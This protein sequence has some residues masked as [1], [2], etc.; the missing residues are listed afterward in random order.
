[1]IAY[2]AKRLNATQR[3]YAPTK[4]ELF[5][6]VVFIRHFGYYL[7]HRRFVLRTDHRALLQIKTMDPPMGAIG[8]WLDCISNFD[9]QVVYRKGSQHGNAD[10][11]SR[12]DFIPSEHT[13]EDTG[14]QVSAIH[15]PCSRREQLV[16][17]QLED[18]SLKVVHQWIR[19]NR[20]P[21]KSELSGLPEPLRH[22]ADLRASFSIVDKVLMYQE[23]RSMSLVPVWPE[24]WEKDLIIKAHAHLSHRGP[25]ATAAYL[26]ERVYFP[27]LAQKVSWV[28]SRCSP[29]LV[30]TKPSSR[31]Q[32]RQLHSH[33]SPAPWHTLSID[34]VGPFPPSPQNFRYLLTEKDLFTRWLE[35]F[36]TKDMTTDTVMRILNN[37]LFPRYGYPYRIHADNGTQFASN[38]FHKWC[39]KFGIRITHTPP[40]NPR[41]NPVE[42]AHRDL[43]AALTALCQ[44][45]TSRWVEFLPQ[46]LMAQRVVQCSSTG[47]SPFQLMFGRKPRCEL[48]L[49]FPLPS[50][51][52]VSPQDF[53]ETLFARQQAAFQQA[54][55]VAAQTVER[56]RLQYHGKLPKFHE[57][58]LVWVFIPRP[59]K[60]FVKLAIWWTG[61]WIVVSVLNPLTYAVQFGRTIKPDVK[62]TI[63]AVDRLK[64]YFDDETVPPPVSMDHNPGDPYVETC[65]LPQVAQ[66]EL[67]EHAPEAQLSY[68]YLTEGHQ[69]VVPGPSPS[70]PRHTVPI[71]EPDK[72]VNKQTDPLNDE[73]PSQPDSS[74]DSD[75]EPESDAPVAVSPEAP[76]ATGK[77]SRIRNRLDPLPVIPD[78]PPTERNL[79]YLRR[80]AHKNS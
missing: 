36:P 46:A 69:P 6:A 30:K 33:A 24:C 44:N 78:V 19:Q 21:S 74:S 51:L 42:R 66:D 35:A 77:Y 60:R 18:R 32:H 38:L 1:M 41:S 34:F 3:N 59:P 8:R 56:Q 50:D 20:T 64:P 2:A 48:D 16:K 13:V 61:P 28:I 14:E 67:D 31:G 55:T 68:P 15:L 79:R 63:V 65:N 62:H 54:R 75:S 12:A 37:E 25:E 4:G 73:F 17:Q 5:A 26:Q 45:K 9:F 58:Q 49:L 23:P 11:L 72:I 57:G 43:E 27:N 47:S 10:A 29:C 76:V 53:A 40:Y 22:F 39:Q 80:E 7:R 70:Y 52:H 71:S